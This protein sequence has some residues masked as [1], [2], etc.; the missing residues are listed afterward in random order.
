MLSRIA[1]AQPNSPNDLTTSARVAS[2]LRAA[3]DR[4]SKIIS[5]QQH[6]GRALEGLGTTCLPE[7][8]SFMRNFSTEELMR[9]VL[10]ATIA[11]LAVGSAAYAQDPAP[12]ADPSAT[13]SPTNQMD[14][15][16]PT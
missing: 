6:L 1:L 3:T 15:A 14:Q 11:A 16:T 5:C 7:R 2:Q 12:K 8:L 4:H 9:H 13:P 10:I